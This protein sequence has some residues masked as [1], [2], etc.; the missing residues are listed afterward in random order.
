VHLAEQ[1]EGVGQAQDLA[2][3]FFP[4]AAARWVSLRIKSVLRVTS[5]ARSLV[6]EDDRLPVPV[7]EK[8]GAGL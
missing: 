2:E 8:S 1:P 3:V 7:C 5:L 6:E 4:A